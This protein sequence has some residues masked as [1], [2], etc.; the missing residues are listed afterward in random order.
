MTLKELQKLG[1]LSS[2]LVICKKYTAMSLSDFE[3][4]SDDLKKEVQAV[5]LDNS[6]WVATPN[7]EPPVRAE[8]VYSYDGKNFGLWKRQNHSF[9]MLEL[10]N[11]SLVATKNITLMEERNMGNIDLGATDLAAELNAESAKLEG[12]PQKMSV[13]GT[14][15]PAAK[16]SD[17]EKAA[18]KQRREAARKEREAKL[19]RDADGIK[20]FAHNNGTQF[21]ANPKFVDNNRKYGRFLGF[22]VSSDPVVKM[23]LK[24]TPINSGS[25]GNVIYTARQ[26]VTLTKEQAEKLAAGK[27]IGAKYL[28]CK[29]DIVVRQAGPGSLVAGIVKTPQLTE[30]S[31]YDVATNKDAQTFNSDC[32]NDHTTILKVLSKEALF[33][34]LELNYDKKIKE[35]ESIKN[36]TMLTVKS[37]EVK[38]ANAVAGTTATARQFRTRIVAEG[39]QLFTPGNYFPLETYD[40]V[41]IAASNAAEKELLNNNFSALLK[42]YNSKPRTKADGSTPAPKGE[43]SAEANKMFTMDSGKSDTNKGLYVCTSAVVNN[44]EVIQCKPFGARGK[45]AP[46]MDVTELPIRVVKPSKH[47]ESVTYS[48]KKS[49][50]NEGDNPAIGRNEYQAFINRVTEAAD[51]VEFATLAASAKKV[52]RTASK[53]KTSV[54]VADRISGIDMLSLRSAKESKVDNAASINDLFDAFRNGQVI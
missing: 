16:K 38:S 46:M 12:T 9:A 39:R 30:I 23:S 18:D 52:S 3:K 37:T 32:A 45:D 4:C 14:I 40:T 53:P 44:G 15:A 36:S 50:F 47:G 10:V 6:I 42:Q 54:S 19:E 5:V 13:E 49:K 22:F 35:D 25:A 8:S 11:G 33:A 24:Q 21:Y 20:K 51:G 26:D 34:Y 41:S 29:T 1:C 28:E 17:A 31:S 7:R 43:F 48:Y 2:N 27:N